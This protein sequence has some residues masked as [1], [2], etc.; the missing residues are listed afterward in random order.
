LQRTGHVSSIDEQHPAAVPL[1]F[2]LVFFDD[3][4]IYSLSMAEHL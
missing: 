2:V 3:I 1:R 4:L